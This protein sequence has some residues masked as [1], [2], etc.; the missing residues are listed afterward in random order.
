MGHYAIQAVVG[1]T[2]GGDDHLAIAFGQVAIFLEHQ[3]IVVREKRPPFC[4]ATRQR[5]KHI[6]NEARFFLHFQH[7]GADV[8]R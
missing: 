4:W 1:G 6:G 5:Q 7:F 2:G 3:G 8:F